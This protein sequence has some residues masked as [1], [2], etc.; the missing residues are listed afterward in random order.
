MKPAKLFTIS[1]AVLCLA[2]TAN[3]Q[4]T[5]LKN[6]PDVVVGGSQPKPGKP[7]TTRMVQGVVR[8]TADNPV[9]GAVVEIKNEKTSKIIA[10]ITKDDGK[11]TFRD[12]GLDVQYDLLAKRGDITTPVKKLSPYDTRKEVTLNFRIEPPSKDQKP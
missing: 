5:E 1:L 9:S 8:D 10:F 11:Y 6:K 2:L 12:L 7:S 4:Q 3:A